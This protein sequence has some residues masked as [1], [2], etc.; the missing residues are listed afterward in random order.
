[1]WLLANPNVEVVVFAQFDN[2]GAVATL[3]FLW[4]KDAEAHGVRDASKRL[5]VVNGT[6][7][8]T[9]PR[10]FGERPRVRCDV[11]AVETATDTAAAI[12]A[13]RDLSFMANSQ[14]HVR[15]RQCTPRT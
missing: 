9:I 5:I 11:V 4:S 10:L 1:M 8:G 7:E 2:A 14:F 15:N 13:V 3:V 12:T 6:A